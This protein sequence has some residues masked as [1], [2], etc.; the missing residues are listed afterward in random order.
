MHNKETN[1]QVHTTRNEE[2]KDD[3]ETLYFAY[4][5]NVGNVSRQ[6]ANEIISELHAKLGR[7]SVNDQYREKWFYVPVTD[8]QTRIE[9][10]YAKHN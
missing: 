3:R 7:Q 8:G 6:K 4:Y 10:L 2:I 9:L 5:V 1:F